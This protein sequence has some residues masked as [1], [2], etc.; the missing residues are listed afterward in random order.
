LTLANQKTVLLVSQPGIM[1]KTLQ[2]ILQSIPG[3]LVVGANGALTAYELLEREYID[4]VVVDANNPL[5]ERL[6]LLARIKKQFPQIRC[7]VLTTTSRN[8][9]RL[10]AA[11]ADTILLQNCSRQ[12]ME[13]AVLAT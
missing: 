10:S 3:A 8:Q 1:H 12:D 4:V 13:T 5:E 11:G 9:H 6:A 2:T 7:I